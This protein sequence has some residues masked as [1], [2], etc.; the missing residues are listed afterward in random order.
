ME[1]VHGGK[2][3]ATKPSSDKQ[4]SRE[5]LVLDREINHSNHTR[6]V[7]S[8]TFPLSTSGLAALCVYCKPM[9]ILTPP[10]K[11]KKL[12][13]RDLQGC[14]IS[15]VPALQGT[16]S[17]LPGFSALLPLHSQQHPP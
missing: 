15:I 10:P 3:R 16:S 13:L 12:E 9:A 8:N 11:H 7:P 14:H 4:S 1:S 2:P 6:K 17:P 5:G